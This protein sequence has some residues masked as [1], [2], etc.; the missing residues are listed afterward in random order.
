MEELRSTEALDREIREDARKKADRVLRA[1][2]QSAAEA[3]AKWKT[4]LQ[5]DLAEL[6]AKHAA[7]VAAMAAETKARLPLDK[8]RLRSERF[9]R[10]LRAAMEKVLRALPRDRVL[11]LLARELGLRAEELPG[12]NSRGS[13]SVRFSGLGEAEASA[14]ISR[15]FGEGSWKI[16]GGLPAAGADPLPALSVSGGKTTVRASLAESGE[17]LLREKRAELASAL[18]GMEALDD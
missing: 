5:A 18:L 9:E 1:A 14:V 17:D 16:A 4:K 3:E 7:R 6:E 12:G 13:L 10:L 15:V 11:D 8:R 2:E